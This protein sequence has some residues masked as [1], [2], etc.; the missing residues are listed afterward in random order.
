MKNWTCILLLMGFIALSFTSCEDPEV[1]NEEELITTLEYTL[2]SANG[3]TTILTFQDLDGD[4]GVLPVVT[5]ATLDTSAIYTGS[6]ALRNDSAN[7]AEDVTAEINAEKEEHQFFFT[8]NNGLD[9]NVSYADTDANGNPVGLTSTLT[10]GA[11][12]SGTLT[13]TLRHEPNKS[14]TNVSAGDITNAGGETD[15]EISF[16]ITIQ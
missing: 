14:G 5:G 4:G 11:A 10:T 9:V 2:T 6:L 8:A 13:I 3:N 16:P 15:I 12:S 1:E 7:P